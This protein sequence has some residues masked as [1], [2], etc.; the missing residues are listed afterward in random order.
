[1]K[2]SKILP[3]MK[4]YKIA[5]YNHNL[6]IDFYSSPKKDSSIEPK[7]T[8]EEPELSKPMDQYDKVVTLRTFNDIEDGKEE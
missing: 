6:I 3:F 7:V 8:Y 4:C 1:M 5:F 2:E